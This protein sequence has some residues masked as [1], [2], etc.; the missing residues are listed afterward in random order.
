MHAFASK[1]CS[2]G[3]VDSHD[4]KRNNSN[5]MVEEIESDNSMYFLTEFVSFY[6][7]IN[8][9]SRTSFDTL[10]K[11]DF[12]MKAECKNQNLTFLYC[13]YSS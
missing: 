13:A 3:I 9:N 12:K 4:R 10:S 1:Q 8:T 7:Q 6:Q 2:S 5:T 11:H